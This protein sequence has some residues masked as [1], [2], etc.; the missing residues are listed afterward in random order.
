[1]RI[2]NTAYQ[3]EKR[4]HLHYEAVSVYFWAVLMR[5]A[6]LKAWR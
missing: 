5:E 2:T 3:K 1:M 4:Y 6:F